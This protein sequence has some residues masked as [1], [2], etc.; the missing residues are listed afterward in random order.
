MQVP[1]LQA[2]FAAGLGAMTA[3]ATPRR[4][5]AGRKSDWSATA[6]AGVA[7]VI[8]AL[9]AVP[10]VVSR[11]GGDLSAMPTASAEVLATSIEAGLA[12]PKV[13]PAEMAHLEVLS[14]RE[15][16]LRPGSGSAW[17]R[18]A[19]VDYRRGDVAA[20]NVALERSLAVA[21]LQTSLFASRTRLAYEHW[22]ELTPAAREQVNYQAHVEFGRWDGEARL[23]ALANSTQS[24]TAQIGL[25]FLIMTERGARDQ[26]KAQTKAQ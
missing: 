9:F 18:K 8:S 25:V 5:G 13:D 12:E 24:P 6:F 26:A 2:V 10:L 17:L 16:A 4:A 1:A 7:L 15:L 23:T 11:F 14:R 20:A 21:P 19:A 22:I 3:T